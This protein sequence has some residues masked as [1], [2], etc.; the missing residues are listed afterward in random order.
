TPLLAAGVNL[1]SNCN[2]KAP[3]SLSV[4]ISPPFPSCW[5]LD[6]K[7]VKTPS[8]I[9]QPESG[10]CF[11][12]RPLHPLDVLPSHNNLTPFFFSWPDKVFGTR[13][14]TKSLSSGLGFKFPVFI[15]IFFQRISSPARE[16]S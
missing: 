10:K 16:G 12:S 5:P 13:F 2:S 7:T 11:L 1:N 8:C 15:L 4:I 9:T 14:T 3:Y 6:G